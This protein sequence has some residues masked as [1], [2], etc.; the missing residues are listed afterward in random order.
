[1]TNRLRFAISRKRFGKM[2]Y[3]RRSQ[4]TR[5]GLISRPL[6]ALQKETQ[7][8]DRDSSN[9]VYQQTSG[10]RSRAV[11][12]IVPPMLGFKSFRIYGFCSSARTFALRLPSENPTRVSPCL[13]LVI[14]AAQNGDIT[15]IFTQLVM[16][17]SGVHAV[18]TDQLL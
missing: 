2:V 18:R 3:R 9:Q 8:P 5:A 7:S 15:G 4:S 17:M 16:P 1:V 6:E 14:V 13:R 12:R 10:A 11:K